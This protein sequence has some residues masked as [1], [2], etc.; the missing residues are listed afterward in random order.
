MNRIDSF[1]FSIIN[2]IFY[3]EVCKSLENANST[4]KKQSDCLFALVSG[5]RTSINREVRSIVFFIHFQ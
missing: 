5:T 2:F 1:L 4:K 3:S